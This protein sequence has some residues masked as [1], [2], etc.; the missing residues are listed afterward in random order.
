MRLET[1]LRTWSL[2][3]MSEIT[4]SQKYKMTQGA[5][6]H[7]TLQSS[8]YRRIHGNVFIL[9]HYRRPF[10][11]FNKSVRYRTWEVS[12]R[13]CGLPVQETW[14]CKYAIPLSVK[15]VMKFNVQVGAL[16]TAH[17][18]EPS[19]AL[20]HH[21][22]C[23]PLRSRFMVSKFKETSLPSAVKG[24]QALNNTQMLGLRY[25]MLRQL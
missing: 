9:P 21:M 17:D 5:A 15:Q 1:L 10:L 19:I 16:L 22:A 4:K 14:S 2:V 8:C 11:L 23:N 6:P 3:F 25:D 13:L 18:D 24:G 7:W 12:I 20:S